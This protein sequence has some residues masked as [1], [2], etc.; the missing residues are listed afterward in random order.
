MLKASPS[1]SLTSL[2]T[3]LISYTNHSLDTAD[4]K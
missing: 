2:Q 4:L 3:L 1:V